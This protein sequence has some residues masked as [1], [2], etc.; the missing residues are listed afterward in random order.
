MS[1]FFRQY[2]FGGIV[3]VIDTHSHRRS[4]FLWEYTK[5]Q[6]SVH[7]DCAYIHTLTHSGISCV[8]M[9]NTYTHTH[10]HTLFPFPRAK[11]HNKSRR[12]ALSPS[13]RTETKEKKNKNDCGT[14]ALSLSHFQ[15]VT[16][17]RERSYHA[18]TRYLYHICCHFYHA[19]ANGPSQK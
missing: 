1:V 12:Y 18:Y 8:Y 17:I 4:I 9:K 15:I 11:V 5:Q 13:L 19:F 10:T 3:Y 6:A 7:T 2:I 14:L 16:S